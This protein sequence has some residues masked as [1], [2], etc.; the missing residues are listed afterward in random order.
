MKIGSKRR[1]TKQTILDDK[2]EAETKALAIEEKLKTIDRL[3][4]E[5][6]NAKA[7]Q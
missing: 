7:Q 5:L 4:Q 6:K 1:R 3:Q 2:V